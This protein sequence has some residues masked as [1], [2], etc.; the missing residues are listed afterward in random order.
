MLTAFAAASAK[1]TAQLHG[2]L[3]PERQADVN[4][5]PFKLLAERLR[6]ECVAT[7]PDG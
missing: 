5:G 6:I 2:S 7:C 1:T 4:S 3:L